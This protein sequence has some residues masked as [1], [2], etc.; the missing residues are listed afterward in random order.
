MA[1]PIAGLTIGSAKNPTQLSKKPDNEKNKKDKKKKKIDYKK[2]LLIGTSL[3]KL[4]GGKD[5]NEEARLSYEGTG[6]NKGDKGYV[7]PDTGNGKKKNGKK[8][9]GGY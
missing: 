1:N 4:A 9:N 5:Y 3:A 2:W 8:K 6:Y 7:K